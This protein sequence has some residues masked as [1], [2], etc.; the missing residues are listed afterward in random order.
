MIALC[1]LFFSDL[2]TRFKLRTPNETLIVKYKLESMW[3][4]TT[5]SCFEVSARHCSGETEENYV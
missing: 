2:M 1:N 5:V 3:K 4:K